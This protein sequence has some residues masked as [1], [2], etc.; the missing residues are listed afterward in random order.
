MYR[1]ERLNDRVMTDRHA[2]ANPH[3]VSDAAEPRNDDTYIQAGALPYQG[4]RRNKSTWMNERGKG[5]AQP[6]D[7]SNEPVP[8]RRRQAA[9][10]SVICGKASDVRDPVNGKI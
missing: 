1:N 4:A 2:T 5:E 8:M 10:R 6:L 9:D 7:I 3:M